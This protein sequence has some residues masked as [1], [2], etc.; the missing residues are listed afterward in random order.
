MM[1][2]ACL[3]EWDSADMLA[4]Y[5][6]EEPKIWN[7]RVL[8]DLTEVATLLDC[9]EAWEVAERKLYTQSDGT[10]VVKWRD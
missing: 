7:E 2:T 4:L 8:G 3:Q 10:F 9:L 1:T 5:F 6:D